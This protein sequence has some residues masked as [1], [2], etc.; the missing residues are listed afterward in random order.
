GSSI[1]VPTQSD[2]DRRIA[3]V[4]VLE[5]IKHLEPT[6]RTERVHELEASS[7]SKASLQLMMTPDQVVGLYRAGM[8]V[9][10]HTRS[11]PM[12]LS[13]EAPAAEQEIAGGL[14]DLSSIVG[15]RPQIFAYPNGKLHSD[16][17]N[18]HV[19]MVQRAGCRYAF[20]THAGAASAS[21]SRFLMPRSTP[22]ARNRLRFR[23]QALKTLLASSASSHA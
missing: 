1:Q 4:T 17:D 22:W 20:T 21:C 9:G 18:R 16:F 2:E 7:D 19:E 23:L 6:E 8:R 14:D 11:H 12:L 5:A 15:E 10:G 3:I 13:L